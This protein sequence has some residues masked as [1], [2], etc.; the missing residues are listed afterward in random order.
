MRACSSRD[1]AA[2]LEA[3]AC[4]S[5]DEAA[6]VV[7]DQHRPLVCCPAPG[8]AGSSAASW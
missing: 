6:R 5:R 2:R 4:S 1:E 3:A 7:R 8:V